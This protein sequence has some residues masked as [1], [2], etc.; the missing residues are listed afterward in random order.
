MN[1]ILGY[2]CLSRP[3]SLM[4]NYE[5]AVN[6]HPQVNRYRKYYAYKKEFYCSE[7]GLYCAIV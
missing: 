1:F 2:S 5:V 4:K 3:C 7:D 6:V